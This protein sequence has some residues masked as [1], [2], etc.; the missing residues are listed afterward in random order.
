MG[1]ILEVFDIKYMPQTSIRRQ[2]LVDL[3]AEFTES[4]MEVEDEEQ[5]SGG[6]QV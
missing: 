6:K 3:V 2:V 1:T 4:S 5:S